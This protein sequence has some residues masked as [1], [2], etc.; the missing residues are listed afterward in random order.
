MAPDFPQF[1]HELTADHVE[2]TMLLN[3]NSAVRLTH[4]VLSLMIES[5]LQSR[6]R[7]YYIFNIGSCSGVNAAPLLQTYA[8]TKAFL[9]KWSVDLDYELKLNGIR[10]VHVEAVTSWTVVSEIGTAWYIFLNLRALK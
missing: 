10:N 1:F 9:A 3:V 8:G 4:A 2:K 7:N 5:A 6:H